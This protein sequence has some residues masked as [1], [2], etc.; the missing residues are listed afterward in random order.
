MKKRLRKLGLFILEKRRLRVYYIN[1]CKYFKGECKEDG[2]KLFSTVPSN[3]QW[4]Q[5]QKEQ[6][7]HKKTLFFVVRVAENR[8]RLP[9]DGCGI[10]LLR[11]SQRFSGHGQG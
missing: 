11:D 1:V 8:H 10:S 3:R 4:L 6:S 7:E 5:T 9:Q 2:D